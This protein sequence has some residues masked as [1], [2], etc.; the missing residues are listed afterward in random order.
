MWPALYIFPLSILSSPFWLKFQENVW[1][2]K[3]RFTPNN[4][5]VFCLQFEL[6]CTGFLSLWVQKALVHH[7]VTVPTAY[8]WT[9]MEG[10][11]VIRHRRM[12]YFTSVEQYCFI[13]FLY[14]K[15]NAIYVK[16]VST[17]FIMSKIV[18]SLCK[19]VCFFILLVFVFIH[20]CLLICL[21]WVIHCYLKHS[22]TLH[23]HVYQMLLSTA[24]LQIKEHLSFCQHSNDFTLIF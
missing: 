21:C 13:S 22:Q 3:C 7:S 2:L 23:L 8:V 12:L 18:S 15:R 16:S 19:Y 1:Q 20:F 10:R 14:Y 17:D 4:E 11:G 6:L 9:L 24:I 5:W